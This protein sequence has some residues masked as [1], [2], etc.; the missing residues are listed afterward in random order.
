MLQEHWENPEKGLFHN[1]PSEPRT[2]FLQS[3]SITNRKKTFQPYRANAKYGLVLSMAESSGFYKYFSIKEKFSKKC[4]EGAASL[5]PTTDLTSLGTWAISC[6]D[7][8]PNEQ[9]SFCGR[10]SDGGPCAGFVRSDPKLEFCPGIGDQVPFSEFQKA[11]N[12]IVE[13]TATTACVFGYNPG[14]WNEF[15]TNGFPPQA[16]AGV[17]IDPSRGEEEWTPSDAMMC[18]YLQTMIPNHRTSWPMYSL[19]VSSKGSKLVKTRILSC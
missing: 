15:T 6:N 7:T 14:V 1:N 4:A 19:Y 17:L 13:A 5:I 9:I 10:C 18:N 12:A 16:L 3:V 11:K 8:N 2:K